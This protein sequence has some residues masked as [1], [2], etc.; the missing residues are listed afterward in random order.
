MLPAYVADHY[1]GPL[2][3]LIPAAFGSS[4]LIYCWAAITSRGGLTAFAVVYGLCASAIQ[5]LFPATLSS[6]TTDLK[7]TGV[8]MGMVFSVVSFACLTGPPLAGALIQ[9]DTGDYLYAQIF[10]GTSLLCGCLTLVAA[11]IVKVGPKLKFRV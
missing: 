10:A 4:L 7:R 6:L 9:R 8:K 1:S 2:N 5:A 3:M 11:R